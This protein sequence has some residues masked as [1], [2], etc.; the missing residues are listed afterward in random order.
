MPD[1][2]ALV[3]D[4][5]AICRLDASIE[6]VRRPAS[7]ARF[8]LGGR[9]I[10]HVADFEIVRDGAAL[11]VDVV[12]DAQALRHPLAAA[13]AVDEAEAVDGRRLVFATA[14]TIRAEP[15]YATVK[16]VMACR[17][18]PVSAGDRV[19]ILH[20]LDECGSASLVEC[21]GAVQNH[22]DGVAAVLALAVE[23]FIALD[24]DR[25]ILPETMLRRRKL[26]FD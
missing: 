18:T 16:L 2:E 13:V 20:H 12:T 19:R 22:S 5:A 26:A 11:L 14:A 1:R 10:E 7:P 8:D 6:A 23:G 9:E 17:H 15:R 25:P 21:A 4:F 3:A 24:I